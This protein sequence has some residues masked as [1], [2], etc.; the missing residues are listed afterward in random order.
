MDK[1]SVSAKAETIV[2]FVRTNVQRTAR[3]VVKVMHHSVGLIAK[4]IL[5]EIPEQLSRS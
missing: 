4:K 1:C 5:T 3:N 2:M